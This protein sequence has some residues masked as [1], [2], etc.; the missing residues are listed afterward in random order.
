MV[1]VD[2]THTDIAK[3]QFYA[4]LGVPEFWRFDGQ[5]WRIY[6]LES[7]VYVEGDRSPMFP[8]VP[9][10]WLYEFLGM[11]REDEIGAMGWLRDRFSV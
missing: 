5:I 11:A 8:Q 4:G 2:I 7:G 10:D 3:N 1:E 6:R 9:K